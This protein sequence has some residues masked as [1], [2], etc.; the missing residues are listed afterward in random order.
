MT[1]ATATKKDAIYFHELHSPV[2]TMVA[3][4]HAGLSLQQKVLSPK[5]FYDKKGSELFD[6]ITRLPEYYPTRTEI[7]L[8]RQ[9]VQEMAGLLGMHSFLLE[10]GSGS[11][12]KIRLLLEAVRPRIYVPMDISREHLIDS[13]QRLASDY[14]WLTVHAACVDYSIPWDIP[15]FGPGR[16][17]AFFPGSSIGNFDPDSA[18]QLLKQVWRL[19]GRGGG[20]L[21][22]V[23][24]KKDA[25]ILEN[26]YNDAQGVTADFNLNVLSHINQRLGADF[27]TG[28]FRH[29]ALYNTGEGRIEM[30]LECTSDHRVR[31]NGNAYRFETGETI[32]TEN[33][34][35]Y[36]VDEFH[37]LAAQ[38]D[39]VPVKVWT[40]PDGLFSIHYLTAT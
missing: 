30:H 11:S 31:I 6:T 29:K 40:D 8:L 4:V 25:A 36:S 5:Y 13:A 15:D 17:N 7:G 38:A 32:H 14:P 12:T 22:G 10:F 26:A 3:E 34:Y 9:H 21:I 39:F 24:L 27:D 2:D 16:Y 28:N 23:D 37:G 19:V 18:L 33:S 35:K 20:L 1:P